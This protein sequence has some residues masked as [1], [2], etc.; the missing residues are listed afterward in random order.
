MSGN[1]SFNADFGTGL[2]GADLAALLLLHE[3][4]HQVGKWGNDS[5]VGDK[6]KNLEHSMAVY[7]AC[8]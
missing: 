4:G 2:K 3:L 6:D 7:K 1:R 5:G 8:F